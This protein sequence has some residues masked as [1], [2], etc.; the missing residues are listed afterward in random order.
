M[1][2]KF[3]SRIEPDLFLS[4]FFWN[5]FIIKQL[6]RSLLKISLGHKSQICPIHMCDCDYEALTDSISRMT[7]TT[8][9]R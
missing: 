9:M 3:D 8:L 6:C 5:D 7:L 1:A 4:V 2:M